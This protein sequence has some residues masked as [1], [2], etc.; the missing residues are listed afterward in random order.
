MSPRRKVHGEMSLPG[1]KSISHRAALMSLLCEAPLSIINY[2]DGEDC[3]SSLAAIK[4]MGA[5]VTT[6]QDGSLTITPPKEGNTNLVAIDCGN[7]GTTCRLL[8]GILSGLGVTAEIIGDNSLSVRPMTRVTDPLEFMGGKF[9]S[10]AN[11]LPLRILGQTDRSIDYRMPIA[12]AQVKSAIILAAIASGNTAII[13]E[14]VITRDHTELLLSHLG[15]NISSQRPRTEVND[16]PSD[17]RKKI[18][19][20]LDDWKSQIVVK[21]GDR[22]DGGE[23]DIPGDMST[24][25]FFFA[26]A[27]IGGGEVTI[28][29]LGLNPT[30][31]SFLDYLKTIG[32]AVSVSDKNTISHELRGT[33]TVV[34]GK[35]KSRRISGAQTAALIDELPI[36][37]V[38]ACFSEGTTVI[39]DAGELRHKETDR[40]EA[41]A[42]NLRIMGANVGSLEDGLVIEAKGDL[43][44]GD[45]DSFGD[46]RIAMAM[47]VAALFLPGSSTLADSE[48]VAVSC[49]T[50]FELLASITS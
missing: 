47:A 21:G 27:A 39:R 25:A 34:G 50:F 13:T 8:I 7:S 4:T 33:V 31:T 1:D 10:D 42:K 36:I 45:F 49:P 19:S 41:I 44:P 2:A 9:S 3:A 29:N 12:S 22:L 30:R 48:S 11:P 26:A 20:I 43:Q 5:K 23:V 40:I 28:K 17:P 18:R 35:L 37:S 16:D 38:I 46:H 24:A 14:D 15:A 32:C 6:N